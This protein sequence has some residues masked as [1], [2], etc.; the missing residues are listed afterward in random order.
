M[1]LALYGLPCAGKTTLL[2]ALSDI[3]VV[4]GSQELNRLSGGKF[5]ELSETEKKSIRVQYAEHLNSLTDSTIISDGHYSFLDDIVFT[6]SD[7]EVYDIFLYLYCQPQILLDRYQDS[8]KNRKYSTLSTTRLE[9]WQQFEIE[10][11]RAECHS[12]CKD[13]YVLSGSEVTAV[14]LADFI[15]RIKDGFSSYHLAE[16]LVSKIRVLYPAPCTLAIADGDKTIIKQDSFRVCSSRTTSIFEGDF[17]TGYQAM[18]FSDAMKDVEYDYE[19]IAA[20]EVNT[21]LYDKIKSGNYIVLSAGITALWDRISSM[22]GIKNV[23]AD[24]AVSADTKYFVV[25]LLQASG[26]IINAYGD[27]KNDIYM[28]KKADV[29]YLY[30][31]ERLSKSLRG[32]NLS[33]VRLLYDKSPCILSDVMDERL[34]RDIA[35]CKSDSGIN[36]AELASS[37]LRLG[38]ELGMAIREIIPNENSA[39]LVL[40]RGG[41]FFGD[42]LYCAFGGVFY[43]FDPAIGEFPQINNDIVIIVDSVI[44]TGSSLMRII[45]KI[46]DRS[47]DTEIIIATNVI[48]KASLERFCEHKIF[49]IRA[50]DNYF[51]GKRQATQR[52]NVGPDTAD[53]LFNLIPKII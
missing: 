20:I 2:S 25:K 50:S 29:G 44:N 21:P 1:K 53:R 12:R 3:R 23:F 33:G 9:A 4:N 17:Y 48:Q 35:I 40:E 51:V 22:W 32:V 41:R 37:H 47:P 7:A 46:R 8:D 36:G 5:S 49:A 19:R 28:L 24:P 27:S 16:E 14:A 15:A 6:D 39:V 31:G 42:G 52:G 26:Y 11:L 45:T 10:H 30:I 18:L 38:R 13:F 34:T 43:S